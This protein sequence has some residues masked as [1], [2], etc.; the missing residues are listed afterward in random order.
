M[1]AKLF[2]VS[3]C[4]LHKLQGTLYTLVSELFWPFSQTKLRKSVCPFGP[5]EFMDKRMYHTL[6]GVL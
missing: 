2:C 5:V 4:L 6:C 3:S 1:V